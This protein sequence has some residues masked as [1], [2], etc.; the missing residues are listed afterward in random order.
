MSSILRHEPAREPRNPGWTF[1]RNPARVH[2]I[3][4]AV[5]SNESDEELKQ[6]AQHCTAEMCETRWSAGAACSDR[7]DG[8]FSKLLDKV[9]I[10][11]IGG[12][13]RADLLL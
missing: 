1:P 9:S 13:R 12:Q 11:K 8:V 4:P 10:A 6:R 5:D 7:M 3:D 2:R